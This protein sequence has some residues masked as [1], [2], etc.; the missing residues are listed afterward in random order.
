MKLVLP[1]VLFIDQFALDRD[2]SNLNHMLVIH[3]L[4]YMQQTEN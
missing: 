4:K 2:T 3:E 1:T